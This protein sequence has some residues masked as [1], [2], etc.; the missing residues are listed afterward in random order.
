MERNSKRRC[1]FMPASWFFFARED[2]LKK[3]AEKIAKKLA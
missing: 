2:K 1:E 3:I